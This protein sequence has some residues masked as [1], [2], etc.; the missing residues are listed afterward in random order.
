MIDTET[1]SELSRRIIAAD[2]RYG[3][4]ASTHEALGVCSEEWDEFREAVRSN[5]LG[6]IRAEALDV[7]AVLIRL[8]DQLMA[9]EATLVFR[10][11]K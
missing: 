5:D 3:M 9:R 4:F 1:F 2:T 6:Q 10:S 7:A 11:G 8:H